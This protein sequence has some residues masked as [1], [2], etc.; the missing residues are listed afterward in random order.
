MKLKV[1]RAANMSVQDLMDLHMGSVTYW[2]S[3]LAK[4]PTVSSPQVR[5][6]KMGLII[7]DL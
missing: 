7:S 5:Y 6:L 4:L 3:D 2:L 1:L